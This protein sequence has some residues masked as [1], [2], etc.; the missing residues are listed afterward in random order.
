MTSPSDDISDDPATAPSAARRT[1]LDAW[2]REPL[3]QFLLIG[4][5]LYGAYRWMSPPDA[6]QPEPNRIVLTSDDLVQMTVAWRAQGRP[7]PTQQQMQSLIE[8]KLR[9]EVLYREAL[10]LGLDKD[11]AIVKRRL[12][13]KMDFVAED[14]SDLA[15]PTP[16]ELKTWFESHRERFALPPRL[17]FRHLYFSPDKRHAAAEADARRALAK[18]DAPGAGEASAAADP[19]MFLDRYVDQS[20]DQVAA[21]FGPA[22]ARSLIEL[23]TG[24]WQG[25][26]E[27]GY[28]WHLVFV[29]ELTPGRVP[30]FD[31]IEPEVK[32]EWIAAQRAESKRKRY[33]AMRARYELVIADTR[34]QP[35]AVAASTPASGTP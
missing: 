31:A 6:A 11:D 27:S 35:A 1:R 26:L 8:T 5:A 19:F 13:Q 10:A 7:M 15:E 29:E 30:D 3:L 17:S 33:E 9:E 25:P 12:A 34:P 23:P 28:G 21:L 2:L 32:R 16:A 20:A 22:F 4:I 24:S 14:L 18:L